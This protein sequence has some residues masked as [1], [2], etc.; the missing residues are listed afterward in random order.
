[1]MREQQTRRMKEFRSCLFYLSLIFFL[2]GFGPSLSWSA[3]G[4]YPERPINM[5]VP[6]APGG[7]LDLGSRVIADKIAEFLGQPLVSVYKPGGG[8]LLGVAFVAKAKSDGYTIVAAGPSTISL[9]TIV[10][11]LDYK[12]DDL[13]PVGNVW[14]NTPLACR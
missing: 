10:K 11:K 6:F 5:V 13:I 4:V 2:I 8:G 14:E 7:A 3:G 9:P 1:M 12:F